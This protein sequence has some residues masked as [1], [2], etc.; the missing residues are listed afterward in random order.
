M[1]KIRIAIAGYGNVGRGVALAAS[2]NTDMEL[3]YVLSRRDPKTVDTNG[4]AEVIHISEA[5]K[6]ADQTDALIICSGSATDLPVQGP[7][8]ASMFNTVDSFDNHAHIPEYFAKMDEVAKSSGHLSLISCGWDPGMFSINRIYSEA[9]LPYGQ[10]YTFWGRGVSQG[11]SDAIRRIPG[12]LRGV[13]YTVPIESSVNEVRN[14]KIISA[15]S[16]DRHRRECYVVAAN[17]A[18]CSKIE[19][20]IKEMPDYFKGYDTTV[21]FISEEEF[22]EKHTGMPHGGF[23]LRSGETAS[24]K[25]QI[26]EYNLKLESNPEFTASVLVACARAV[27]RLTGEG[28]T[29]ARTVFDIPPAY[30]SAYSREQLI[31]SFL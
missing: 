24:G 23:V 19:H 14:G 1:N 21:H 26:V 9:I 5:E 11:H 29:G 7:Q 4:M 30:F 2:Q 28:C 27:A 8:L 17:D 31:K 13:Q 15:D 16:H 18:D 25:K 22:N 6:I 3:K 10:S 12:V 20:D